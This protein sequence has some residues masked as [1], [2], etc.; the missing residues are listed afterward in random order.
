MALSVSKKVNNN[1]FDTLIQPRFFIEAGLDLCSGL[2]ARLL[3]KIH[4]GVK[5]FISLACGS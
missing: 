2:S 3:F 4:S 5:F 1:F